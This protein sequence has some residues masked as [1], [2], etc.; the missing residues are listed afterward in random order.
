LRAAAVSLTTGLLADESRLN[1]Q[2][3]P[4]AKSSESKLIAIDL[5]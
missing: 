4:S 2:F 5:D 3:H 1:P